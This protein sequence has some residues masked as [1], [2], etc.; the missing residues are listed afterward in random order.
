MD[1]NLFPYYIRSL[2]QG[3]GTENVRVPDEQL[4]E[5]KYAAL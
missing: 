4:S 2:L 1:E 5:A 3:S